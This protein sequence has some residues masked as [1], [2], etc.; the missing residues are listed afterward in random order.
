M[1][2]G[3]K[4][5]D[6]RK[7]GRLKHL[8]PVSS[9]VLAGVGAAILSA[10]LPATATADPVNV[11]QHH[12]NPSRDGLYIDPAF[13]LTAAA[14]ITRDTSF[15]GTIVG[16]VYAQPLYIENG[17]G[18]VA[19]IIAVTE[20]NNVYALNAATGGVI[21]HR[22]VGTAVSS[23][24]PCGNVSPVGITGTPIVDLPSR[25]LFLDAETKPSA[26]VF[27]HLIFSLNVDTGAINIGWPVDVAAAV[28]GFD[29]SVQG[30]RAALGIVGNILYVPYGGR[31]GDC[32]SYRGRLVGV[33]LNSPA[34]VMA[35]ATTATGGGVWG[36]GGVAS[37]G[38]NPFVTTGNTF[39]TGGTWKGGEAVIRLL[40][41]PIFSGSTNDYWAPTNWF[42]LDNGDTDL[43]GSGP[44]LV[45]VPGAVPSAL[46]VALGKDGNAYLLNRSNLGGISAPVAQSN[47]NSGGTI[48]QAAA[49]YRTALST[50]VVFRASSSTTTSFRITATNP[51]TIATGWSVT[52]QNGRS[53]PFVTSTDGTSDVIVWVIGAE[54]DQKLH[55]YN[56]DTG[57]V[58]YAGGGTNEV[59]AGT[60]RYNTGIAARGRVYVATNNKVY[61]F[62]VPSST[63]TPTPATTSTP[64]SSPTATAT[65][66]PPPTPTPTPTVTPPPTP[67]PSPTTTPASSCVPP[68]ANMVA[69]W[70]G[71]GN[72]HD[73]QNGNN[74]AL[75]GGTIYSA[76]RVGQAFRLDASTN[77]GIIIP[78]SASLN[79]TDAITIDAWVNPSS[80][81]NTG[82]AIV[83]K[84]SNGVG[85]T[86]YS[87]S[88]GDGLTVGVL[89]CNIGGSVAA[90]GGS[91]PL[92]QWSHVACT[93]DRQNIRVYIN[94]VQVAFAADTQAIP[95]SAQNLAIGKEDRFTDRNFD[96]L[97]DEVEIFNR[98]LTAGEIQSI[99]N[100]GSAGK[101]RTCTPPP[102][103]MVSW[104]PG[105][106]NAQDI[107]GSNNGSL[108]GGATFAPGEVG[109]AFSFN[110]TTAYVSVPD[111]ANLYPSGSFT[112]DAWIKTSQTTGIQ[113]I[114]NHY[115]CA[116]FCTGGVN[117][118][119][120][121]TVTDGKLSGFIRDTT[122]ASQTL[123]GTTAV[124]DGTFHHVAMQRDIAGG[125]MRLYL[126]GTLEASAT[127]VPTGVLKDDDGEPDP[128]TIGAVIQNNNPGCGCAIQFFSGVID[129]VEY[130]SRA[131]TA[132]EIAAI[133]DAGNAGKCKSIPTPTPT[134]TPA[135]VSISG[136]VTYCSNPA[137]PPVPG[138][139]MT[140]TGTT[141]GST[142]TDGSG[143]YTFSSLPAGGNYTVTP[144][145]ATLPSGSAGINTLDVVAAQRQ[146]LN[147]GTPLTGCRLMAADASPVNGDGV[148]NTLD[149]IAIQ[150]FFLSQTTGLGRCGKYQFNPASRSYTA[151]TTNQ[152]VQNY[153]ALVFGDTAGSPFVH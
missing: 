133:A 145:K 106:S 66:T 140:L 52:G 9:L 126:D 102:A 61:A 82:P 79:P 81:P 142:L 105:D 27:K 17:P 32:G 129:E 80:F 139:T 49:T 149:I 127:L 112:V 123:A 101:C 72:P 152:T 100:A 3:K 20:S 111:N 62:N 86:Q 69:W 151:I 84:D 118:D 98:A 26:G 70:P 43:G 141:S 42:D 6:M 135:L 22:N 108:Q 68:P 64:T 107:Q 77:S 12:N 96:G 19:M 33:Q 120:E 55:G 37:D 143:N 51:P 16:N 44:I 117:S 50:Y 94:G 59:M 93:Y 76:G 95:T 5:I 136:T 34:S 53:S 89:S 14:N 147:L 153:N 60:Q 10:V 109:Q 29:S 85:T 137:L 130:F 116:N 88:V 114:I 28:S 35:W 131:L 13:T 103:N 146:F 124:G 73:I 74:G 45:D 83:R 71:D 78:S 56:G 90:S 18:G 57:A 138:V 15:T 48:I 125:Q 99:Y 11:T 63:P 113:Q 134:A 97:I 41:G 75:Q 24:L 54:G 1:A 104:W 40:P 65:P 150:R 121:M 92:N 38:T 58:V 47:V 30:E 144:S 7:Y 31:W 122:G 132:A 39:S 148:V 23:G 25:S 87:L 119:Y 2:P 8:L 91:V 4:E 46:V 115:E 21:W 110:G 67:S 36:A 128:V